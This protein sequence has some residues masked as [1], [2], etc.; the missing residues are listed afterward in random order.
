[1]H[2][3]VDFWRQG[4][5]SVSMIFTLLLSWALAQQPAKGPI[6][7]Q[8]VGTSAFQVVT[9]REVKASSW[10]SRALKSELQN[11]LAESTKSEANATLFEIAI[12]R[13]AKSLGAVSLKK[14]E[15]DSLIL[16]A[17]SKLQKNS[18]WK[19]L[20]VQEDELRQWIERKRT[21]EIFMELKMNSLT[22]IVTDQEIQD[23][24][25][26]NRV[27][28]GSTPLAEQRDTIQKFLQKENQ[29]QRM[30]DWLS[31]LKTKYQVRND[32]QEDKT[33]VAPQPT[34]DFEKAP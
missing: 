3:G 28:F 6:I 10:L 25:D 32:L 7:T 12:Y 30:Q 5:Y 18:E 19:K 15:I 1:M 33:S 13:E 2:E 20:E 9:T 34:T 17:K 8:T 31:A 26:R 23:Y 4:G 27:K 14:E 21:S 22:S 11:T 16:T 24:Y 29:K